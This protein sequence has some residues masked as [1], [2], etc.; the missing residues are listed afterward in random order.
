MQKKKNLLATWLLVAALCLGLGTIAGAEEAP[1]YAALFETGEILDI[2]IEI[3]EADWQDILDNAMEEEFHPAN[4]TIDGITATN[5]GFRTKGNSTLR[6]I[7][8][9][10]SDRYGFRVKLDKYED[11]QTLL[12]LSTFVLNPSFADPSYM[13]EYLTYQAMASLGAPTPYCTF[14]RLSINGEYFGLYLCV[15]AVS[16]SFVERN[17]TDPDAVLY[18]AEGQRSTLEE[19]MDLT[20]FE[21]KYGKDKS[22][23]HI[24]ALVDAHAA[25]TADNADD[26]A[27]IL[28]VDS[29]LKAMAINT[30]MGNYDSYS[31]SMAHNY[32]LLYADGIFQYVGWDYN[33]SIGGFMDYGASVTADVYAP[34]YGATISSRPMIEKLLLSDAYT[35]QYLGYV[36]ALCDYFTDFE[37]TVAVIAD[38]IREDVASDPTAFYTLEDFE[39]NIVAT[40]TDL[41]AVESTFGGGRMG[42]MGGDGENGMPPD[43][44]DRRER[45][46][47]MG[48]GFAPPEGFTFPEDFTPPEGFTMPEDFDWSQAPQDMGGR[49]GGMMLQQ[50]Q[51]SIVDYITQRIAYIQQSLQ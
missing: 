19:S 46:Q 17:T 1:A 11:D 9:S 44:G 29:V 39:A 42:R 4:V 41:S 31:G 36:Q 2:N 43:M 47:D 49:G 21:V 45:P 28:D 22:L 34:V 10:D 25:T 32:F 14:A 8:S 20:Q 35:E 5:V 16:D 37:D 6:S 27:D 12:G 33:M 3:D 30:V 13:R 40:D 23:T 7:A 18:K 38:L 50:N 26:L 15:E 48:E 24:Q 51:P